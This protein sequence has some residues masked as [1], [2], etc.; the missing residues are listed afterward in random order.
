MPRLVI[1]NW[2]GKSLEVTDLSKTL[3]RHFL[4]NRLDWMHACGGKG[5]CT[6][7]KVIVKEGLSNIDPPTDAERKY[8]IE[9]ALNVRERLACQARIVGDVCLLAP[10][11]YRLP[12]IR[13][14]DEEQT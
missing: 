13:Y 9:G 14:S 2:A 8:A 1:V 12:H 3:L 7:C 5:R 4:D 6:T 11:E 10:E